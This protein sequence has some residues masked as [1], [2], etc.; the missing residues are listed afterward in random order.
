LVQ[1]IHR[2]GPRGLGRS[3]IDGMKRALADGADLIF[4][5]DADWSH[6][7]DYLP[8]LAAAAEDADLVIGSR[9][10]NGVSVVNWPLHRIILSTLANR[11]IRGARVS[12]RTTARPAYRCWRK[13]CL[14]IIPLDG[15]I[16][17]ATR[18]SW[19]RSIWPR[20]L[21]WPYH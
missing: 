14:A 13:E 9:Y 17:D 4:E 10:L 3:L 20:G 1:V 2:T 5:M 15:V 7:P 18:S 12:P 16:S 6:N 21:G 11:Y 19:K 8:A